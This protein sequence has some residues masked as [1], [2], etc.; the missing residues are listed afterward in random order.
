MMRVVVL[1]GYGNFGA[2][3]CR[4]L[5][6]D[7]DIDLVVAARSLDKAR[8]FAQ[9]LGARATGL[10]AAAPDL[11]Q[12]LHMLRADLVL[13]TAGPFQQQDYAV[14]KAAAVAGCHYIDLADGRRFVCDFESQVDQDFR[15]A[16]RFATAGASTVPALS[17]AVVQALQPRFSQIDSVGICIAP[18]Q[19]AP[20]GTATLAA[21]LSYCGAPIQ[22]WRAGQWTTGRGWAHPQRVAFSRMR[23][24]LAALCDVPD[25]E[26]F[27]AYFGGVRTVMF[28]AALEVGLTQ[29]AFAVL[30]WLRHIGWLARPAGLASLLNAVGPWLDGFGSALGGM[31][32][33]VR[34]VGTD[35]KALQLAWHITADHNHGPEIPCMAAILLARRLARGEV[36]T[37]GAGPCVGLLRLEEF[38]PEFG[39][40]EMFT[41]LVEEEATDAA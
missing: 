10:D 18:A 40:W 6:G 27:P 12:R 9:G 32:I 33:R 30:S 29:R 38:A 15:R 17:C 14:A 41:D 31:V 36:F 21:V 16:G 1:G 23:P 25:L 11:A 19:Q 28:R 8:A 20:R 39:R 5:A 2:R 35:A 4:A 37:S 26:L 3:I 34:G 22:V 24:R 7:P 13:H